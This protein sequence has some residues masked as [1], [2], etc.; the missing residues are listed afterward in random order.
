MLTVSVCKDDALGKKPEE[1]FTKALNAESAPC[2][3]RYFNRSKG[4]RNTSIDG[5]NAQPVIQLVNS[6]T[7]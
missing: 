7:E 4:S 1:H 2:L 3:K 5:H 6:I